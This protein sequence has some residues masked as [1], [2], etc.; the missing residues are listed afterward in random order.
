MLAGNNKQIKIAQSALGHLKN[1]EDQTKN[2]NKDV[3]R[4]AKAARMLVE[5]VV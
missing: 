2:I 5:S 1:I 4:A 3:N